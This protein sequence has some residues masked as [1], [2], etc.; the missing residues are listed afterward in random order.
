VV[1]SSALRPIGPAGA[2]AG[3]GF[4]ITPDLGEAGGEVTASEM[5]VFPEFVCGNTTGDAF[6]APFAIEWKLVDTTSLGLHRPDDPNA[7]NIVS[8]QDGLPVVATGSTAAP[9]G[10]ASFLVDL[11][12]GLEPGT[13]L[14]LTGTC[15]DA[16]GATVF[17][18]DFSTL[19]EIDGVTTTTTTSTSNTTVAPAA[20]STVPAVAPTV[21]P[22]APA[23]PTRA[24]A[25][26]TG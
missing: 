14:A 19:L 9:E 12:P 22:A 10:G 1:A 4:T 11:D 16:A 7:Q 23:T 6:T 15:V 26:Y 24:A 2:D 13:M 3:A 25:N 20:T 5:T 18:Y 21:A 17:S 8:V